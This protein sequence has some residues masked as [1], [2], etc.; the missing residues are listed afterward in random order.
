MEIQAPSV[1]FDDKHIWN[2]IGETTNDTE[3]G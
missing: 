2:T 3:S 1:T